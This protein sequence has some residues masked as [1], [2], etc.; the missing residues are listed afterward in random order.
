MKALEGANA[1]EMEPM[2]IRSR[3]KAHATEAMA[4]QRAGF[5]RWG[6]IGKR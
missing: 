1:R 3:A 6:V 2:E 5:L 4:D